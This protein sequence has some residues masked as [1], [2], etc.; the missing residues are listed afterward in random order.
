MSVE[1]C[2]HISM[3]PRYLRWVWS[4]QPAAGDGLVAEDKKRHR[5]TRVKLAAWRLP[6]TDVGD[7]KCHAHTA[8]CHANPTPLHH[9]CSG[10]AP[11]PVQLLYRALS[12]RRM[13]SSASIGPG[14]C[15]GSATCTC[16]PH[17]QAGCVSQLLVKQ[18]IVTTDS[19]K[20]H[21]CT[22]AKTGSSCKQHPQGKGLVLALAISASS[23]PHLLRGCY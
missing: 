6:R 15:P 5:W 7:A 17:Q 10:G 20:M 11:S 2:Q 23:A 8:S 22:V 21:M 19:P 18:D 9:L 12:N 1:G 14:A 16:S 3:Y 13:S 4:M